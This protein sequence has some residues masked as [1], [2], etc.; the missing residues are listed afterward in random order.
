MSEV[1][2]IP[3]AL[4]I[5][6]M[7]TYVGTSLVTIF[8]GHTNRPYISE[9]G[10][11]IPQSCVF[12][13][14]LNIACVLLG[15]VVYTRYRQIKLIMCHHKD[16]FKSSAKLNKFA[17][18]IGGGSGFGLSIVA[19][20]QLT[21]VPVVHYL[22]AVSCFFLGNVYFWLQAYISYNVR[23]HVGSTRMTWI[24]FILAAVCS[25]FFFVTIL[26]SCKVVGLIFHEDSNCTYLTA[27]VAS[28]W[29]VSIIFC[30]YL[31]SF[32]GEFRQIVMEHP[33]MSIIGHNGEMLEV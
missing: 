18:W 29:I 16:V 30:F 33:K 14:C 31:L 22:G 11:Y 12:A 1:Y 2:Y 20:F 21:N 5:V 15:I 24:R 6:C 4:F 23:S 8:Q 17:L 28:E 3:V 26:T 25:Y 10:T 27:S 32:A 9:G 19:N 13:E 7:L